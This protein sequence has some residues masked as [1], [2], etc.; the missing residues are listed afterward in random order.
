MLEFEL[1]KVVRGFFAPELLLDYLRYFILFEQGDDGIIKKIAGY[2]QFHAVREAVRATV[3]AATRP[4]AAPSKTEEERATY[5]KRVVPGSR[6]GGI[7]LAHPGF[8]QEHFN[9]VLH[10]QADAAAGDAEPDD[11][12]RH[13]PQRFGWA[14]LPNVCGA[15]ALLKETPQ[16]AE[17]RDQLRALLNGRPSG[18]IIFTTVQKFSP[19]RDEDQFPRLTERTN[20]VVIADEAHRSQYGFNAVLDKKTGK[21]NY[22]FAKHLRDALPNA[23]F[24]GFT[25]TPVET[26][27]KDTRA[28]FGDYVSIYDIQDAVDDGATVPIYY[29]SRLAKLDINQAEIEQ[30]SD[31]VE[32]VFEDEESVVA[33]EAAKTKWAALEKLVGAE[34]RIKEVAADIVQHFEARTAAVDGK[35]MIVAMS[36]QICVDLFDQIVALRP[37]WAGTLV[38]G[39]GTDKASHYSV[40]DGVDSHCHDRLSGRRSEVAASH[41]QRERQE[42][43][44]ETLQEP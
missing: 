26:E 43:T 2:H 36:R 20:V 42:A 44:G 33:R 15:R 32:E 16:Q 6:K 38:P 10:R 37:K 35:A 3:I 4:Q 5:G 27:D 30:L 39:N 11:C 12:R 1:E 18:G 9:G 41:L 25:G 7:V 21:Y 19:E 29:E 14:T 23:T 22:G 8:G 31:Q 24:V 40:D 34:P 17:D 28:V 13:R